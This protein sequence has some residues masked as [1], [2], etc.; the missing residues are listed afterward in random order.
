MN[1]SC[2]CTVAMESSTNKVWLMEFLLRRRGSKRWVCAL[3]LDSMIAGEALATV[4][5]LLKLVNAFYHFIYYRIQR[6]PPEHESD[7][8]DQPTGRHAATEKPKPV[9]DSEPATTAA[10]TG[11]ALSI[12]DD[13]FVTGGSSTSSAADKPPPEQGKKQASS[14]LTPVD[15]GTSTARQ[16]ENEDPVITQVEFYHFIMQPLQDNLD[17]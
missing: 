7:S 9:E 6:R 8:W 11:I 14:K 15:G 5:K 4:A 16:P 1:D 13:H 3:L 17:Q 10:P 12:V 2:V